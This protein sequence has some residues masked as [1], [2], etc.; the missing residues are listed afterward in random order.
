M[1]TPSTSEKFI[2]K[3][4]TKRG[5]KYDYS[6]VKYIHSKENVKIICPDHG[7][8]WQTPNNHLNGADCPSCGVIKQ[9]EC[10]K[11]TTEKF[12]TKANITHNKIYD[13]SLVDYKDSYSKVKIICKDHG[14]FEQKPYVHLLNHGCPSCLMSNG[15]KDIKQYLDFN[16]VVYKLEHRFKE[17]RNKKPLPYDF[18]LPDHN[19]CIEFDGEQHFNPGRWNKDPMK[20]LQKF[21][22]GGIND[23]IK[24]TYCISNKIKLVRIPYWDFDK[25]ETILSE[26]I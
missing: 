1:K 10:K 13:Y 12:I 5:D 2:K 15:A 9:N 3:A 4:I 8:F 22:E 6:F 17:C 24:D 25:I 23:L 18:Y 11:L 21:V 7:E 19:I 14:I 26:Y 20:N 16:K